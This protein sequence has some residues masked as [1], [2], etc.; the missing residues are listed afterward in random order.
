MIKMVIVGAWQQLG[1]LACVKFI[2]EA[3][4]DQVCMMFNVPRYF[5]GLNNNFILSNVQ[6]LSYQYKRRKSQQQIKRL[7]DCNLTQARL[8]FS[9]LGGVL[10][11]SRPPDC[12]RVKVAAKNLVWTRPYINM[13][14]ACEPVT[15]MN[16]VTGRFCIKLQ[17]CAVMAAVHLK[18][19]RLRCK[20][21]RKLTVQI[22]QDISLLHTLLH[23]TQYL[24]RSS[25]LRI[26]LPVQTANVLKTFYNSFSIH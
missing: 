17:L 13:L 22:W 5:I 24:I 20:R 19:C 16:I 15:I 12:N 3:L 25:F 10:L 9:K 26:L 2:V 1:R 11:P 4:F 14:P 21:Q 7:V 8:W 18:Y 23:Y 6:R